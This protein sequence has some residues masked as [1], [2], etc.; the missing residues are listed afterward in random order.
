MTSNE[1]AKQP[2]FGKARPVETKHLHFDLSHYATHDAFSL[3]VGTRKHALQPHTEETRAAA[4]ASSKLLGLIAPDCLTHF[5]GEGIELPAD[6]S[7]MLRVTSPRR[8][9]AANLDT[10]AMVAIHIP[11]RSRNNALIERWKREDAAGLPFTPHPKLEAL[12]VKAP[13]A[14]SPQED[15]DFYRELILEAA[16]VNGVFDVAATLIM[17]HPELMSLK[18]DIYGKV[19]AYVE[20]AAGISDLA[21]SIYDQASN[22]A[23]DPTQ[24]NWVSAVPANGPDLGPDPSGTQVYRWSDTTRGAMASPG[25]PGPLTDVLQN[26]KNDPDLKDWCYVVQ[27][28]TTCVGGHN[29][30]A[31]SMFSK[32]GRPSPRLP[33]AAEGSGPT[34]LTRDVT[35]DSGV[36]YSE[37][38]LDNGTFS[39]QLTNEWIRW[40]S[41]YVEFFGPDEKP[42]A[43]EGWVSF[44]PSGFEYFESDTKKYLLWCPARKTILGIPLTATPT[45]ISFPW[46][47]NNPSGARIYCGGIGIFKRFVAGRSVGGWDSEACM[48]GA[49]LTGIFNLALPTFFLVSGAVLTWDADDD[50]EVMKAIGDFLPVL[51]VI[52]N[53]PVAKALAGGDIG[54]LLAAFA[55][56]LMTVLMKP[57]AKLLAKV[58][59]QLAGEEA[60]EAV[61]FAGWVIDAIFITAEIA[62]ILETTIEVLSSYPTIEIDINKV[63]D[64][65]LTVGPDPSSA[66]GNQWPSQSDHWQAVLQ[67]SDGTT[68][69]Q[70]G[71]LDPLTTTGP[72]AISFSS[73]PAGGSV[74]A[75]FA[76]YSAA[77][78]DRLCG[79][80]ETGFL[81]APVDGGVMTIPSFSITQFPT[82]LTAN[83]QYQ[84]K[85]KLVYDGTRHWSVP[86]GPVPAAT[87]SLNACV[88]ITFSQ[89][90]GALG[91]V[92]TAPG[93][94]L[95]NCSGDSG[96]GLFALQ[97]ISVVTAKDQ[98][99]PS[100]QCAFDA[101]PCLVYDL[102]GPKTQPGRNYYFDPRGGENHLRQVILDGH[103]A[104][105]TAPGQS[106]GRF[107]APMKALAIHPAGYVIGIST[108]LH[109]MEV[110]ILS[111]QPVA[112]A[113]APVAVI[114]SGLGSRAGLLH[115]PLAVVTTPDGRILILD[116]P[117]DFPTHSVGAR[118]QALDVHG[119]PVSSFAGNSAD[120]E[121]RAEASAVTYLDMGVESKGYIYVLKAVGDLS[122]PANYMLDIYSPNG[123]FLVQTPGV[124]AAKMV[125]SLW[126]DVYTLNYE[127]LAGPNGSEPSVSWWSPSV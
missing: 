92:W 106:F 85:T 14:S 51:K 54:S 21:Q 125:V 22:Y 70:T 117:Y 38:K 43:P 66:G 123:T 42:V 52:I 13:S 102:L 67:Y 49:V 124:T 25:V 107:N 95:P 30:R 15:K 74:K 60:A 50:N 16:T 46:P 81:G 34:L 86:P 121:L 112:D 114:K 1:N 29:Q 32:Y 126:R 99:W 116:Q 6:V 65:T 120:F 105:S 101:Q 4:A 82:P 35:P 108:T 47:T 2:G 12:G 33:A 3:H 68:Y 53:G 77:P 111:S 79:K 24:E 20:Y 78:G 59:L 62:T 88:G 23:K 98:T 83:T 75:I 63:M 8:P 89:L 109:K 18:S 37:V 84:Y 41:V 115:T 17:H 118:I 61:P 122:V 104:F 58:G 39:L 97:N 103:T 96:T 9:A 76:V 113:D 44:L 57:F 91:Y 71:P 10:L 31:S 94:S 28:G 64:V 56:T 19:N 27:P 69:Q 93:L 87:G 5:V 80:G 45:T 119:N 40:L 7:I 11:T 72:I 127:M 110:L 55:Q 73:L 90:T 100:P 36:E 48:G 26:T